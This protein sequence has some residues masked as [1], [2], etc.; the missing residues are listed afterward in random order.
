MPVNATKGKR[1]ELQ[2]REREEEKPVSTQLATF[3]ER[4]SMRR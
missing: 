3:L 4:T 1:E 2:I